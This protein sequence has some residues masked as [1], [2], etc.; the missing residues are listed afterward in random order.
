MVLL[1][2]SKEGSGSVELQGGGE[3]EEP[4]TSEES[5]GTGRPKDGPTL[6]VVEWY[7]WLLHVL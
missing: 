5:L 7:S 1:G 3:A 6:Q 4:G 2:A